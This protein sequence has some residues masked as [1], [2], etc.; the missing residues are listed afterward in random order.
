MLLV[1]A[2]YLAT[3]GLFLALVRWRRRSEPE[4]MRDWLWK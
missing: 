1:K 4:R 2:G 3:V